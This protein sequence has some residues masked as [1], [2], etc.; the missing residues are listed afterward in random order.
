MDILVVDDDLTDLTVTAR[1]VEESGHRPIKCSS[2]KEALELVYTGSFPNLIITDWDMPDIGGSE[3]CQRLRSVPSTISPYIILTTADNL[4]DAKVNALETGAD[5]FIEKPISIRSLMARIRVAERIISAQLD[6][7]NLALTDELTGL[8]N[9]R[10]GINAVQTQ[11][12]R[13]NRNKRLHGCIIM[14]DID[15]FKR[16]NDTYGHTTGDIVLKEISSRLVE[17]LRAFDTVCRYGGEEFLIFCETSDLSTDD[18]RNMLDRIMEIIS[19]E[20]VL[21]NKDLSL[22]VTVSIGCFVHKPVTPLSLPQL[23]DKADMLLYK[24]KGSGRN[25]YVTNLQASVY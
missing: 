8:L 13:M 21:I 11:L 14:C 22:A 20:P 24:A 2:A 6:L 5:D 16:I 23:I 7:R 19:K 9:R 1:F 12:A 4:D 15:H 3:F 10:A 18:I 17:S 25:R